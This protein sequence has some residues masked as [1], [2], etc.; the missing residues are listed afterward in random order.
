VQYIRAAFAKLLWPLVTAPH[1]ASSAYFA[2]LLVLR[3]ISF[4]SPRCLVEKQNKDK[5]NLKYK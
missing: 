2:Y 3:Q 1:G 5:D 4:M